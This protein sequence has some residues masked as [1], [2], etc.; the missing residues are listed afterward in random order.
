MATKS[1][2]MRA[3]K[4]SGRGRRRG[5]TSGT[6]VT[7]SGKPQKSAVNRFHQ[8]LGTLTYSQACK[9]LGDEGAKLI[10]SGGRT[11]EVQS[12]RDVF[13]GGDLFRVR[14]EEPDKEKVDMLSNKLSEAIERDEQGR[15]QLK[16]VL[17]GNDAL[18]DL[19]ATLAKLL[20]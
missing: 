4:A 6:G 16:I 17:P 19:A 7:A 20:G 3:S 5:K 11:F 15:P 8:R 1:A 12:D 13:L 10:Q 18:R 2:V 14:V 9:L